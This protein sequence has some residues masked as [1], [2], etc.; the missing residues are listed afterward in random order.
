VRGL[1]VTNAADAGAAITDLMAR[2]QS[3]IIDMSAL[4]FI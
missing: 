4:D 1:D 3:L 2:D